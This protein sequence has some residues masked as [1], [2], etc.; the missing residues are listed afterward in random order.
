M[1][2]GKRGRADTL[3]NSAKEMRINKALGVVAEK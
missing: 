3:V 1:R 2:M